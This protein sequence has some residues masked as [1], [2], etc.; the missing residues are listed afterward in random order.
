MQH[1]DCFAAWTS[2]MPVR[3][4]ELMDLSETPA[5]MLRASAIITGMLGKEGTKGTS[6][7]A[8]ALM[9]D[10]EAATA[11]SDIFKQV[12]SPPPTPTP[13]RLPR[14]TSKQRCSNP[15]SK[16]RTVLSAPSSQRA[17]SSQRWFVLWRHPDRSKGAYNL[18]WYEAENSKKPKGLLQLKRGLTSVANPTTRRCVRAIAVL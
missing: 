18:L 16:Q 13:T 9:G 17:A 4:Q 6:G 14:R 8:K 1:S 11:Q 2:L 12:L 15:T 5:G 10:M 3:S 7:V